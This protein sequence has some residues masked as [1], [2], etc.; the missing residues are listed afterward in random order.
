LK[1]N[2]ANLKDVDELLRGDDLDLF[3]TMSEYLKERRKVEY[4][5]LTNDEKMDRDI[6]CKNVCTLL[7]YA[8]NAPA[9]LRYGAAGMNIRIRE[10]LDPMGTANVMGMT[11]KENEWVAF[12]RKY[13][14]TNY[15]NSLP[16][17]WKWKNQDDK[18]EFWYESSTGKFAVEPKY[19]KDPY[20]EEVP[21]GSKMKYIYLMK[22]SSQTPECY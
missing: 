20:N 10:R 7:E 17:V 4:D 8:N 3:Q 13:Y 1:S 14:N 12:L 22:C 18:Y 21:C 19:L 15:D 2:G 5:R 11:K 6:F 9:N 16:R